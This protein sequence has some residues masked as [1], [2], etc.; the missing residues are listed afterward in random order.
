M[1]VF[2]VTYGSRVNGP[3]VRNVL[4]TQGCSVKCPGC[5]N[6]HT[7]DPEKGDEF[8]PGTV[9]DMLLAGN[10]VD[11]VT[12]SGGEPTDQWPEVKQVLKGVREGGQSVVLFTGRTKAQLIELG[13]WNDLELLTDIVVAG[14]YEREKAL[15]GEP[16]RGSENQVVY[17]HGEYTKKDLAP[18]PEV[19]VHIDGDKVVVAGFPTKET[20]KTLLKEI[21]G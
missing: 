10:P 3:G 11:G 5:F 18:I 8:S 19:E 12:I 17:Y 14:P 21:R 4:H 16:L 7:W 15:R 13:Y 9:V 2:R 6:V 20:R 1:K